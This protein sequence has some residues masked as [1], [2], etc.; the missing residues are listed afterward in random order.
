MKNEL[1]VIARGHTIN[2]SKELEILLKFLNIK[3][4][5]DKIAFGIL[6]DILDTTNQEN[7]VKTKDIAKR[8]GISQAAAI[9]QINKFLEKGFI[10][11]IGSRYFLRGETL[12]ET[13]DEMKKDYLRKMERIKKVAKRLDQFLYS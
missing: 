13:I 4:N 3:P 8:A 9:Y 12:E 1:K 6:L 11:K 2:L 5:Q 7:G 10:K